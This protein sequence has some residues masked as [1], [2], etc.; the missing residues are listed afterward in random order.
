MVVKWY[1]SS[2]YTRFCSLNL[3]I[4]LSIEHYK[5]GKKLVIEVNQK[6]EHCEEKKSEETTG[7]E[8]GYVSTYLPLT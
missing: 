2:N 3:S 5:T 8:W 6:H 7:S 4:L 1:Y